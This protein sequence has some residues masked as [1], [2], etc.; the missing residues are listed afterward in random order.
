M[1]VHGC[2]CLIVLK[3][4]HIEIDIPYSSE[5][6]REHI[7]F[8]R[9]EPCIEGDEVCRGL[10]KSIGVTGCVVAPLILRNTPLL[11]LL[12]FGL[13]D[14]SV[15]V[16]ET[17]NV[18]KSR[19]ELVPF[20]DSKLFDLI[21]SRKNNGGFLFEGCRVNAFELRIEREESI[22][23]RI[24]VL[25]ERNRKKYLFDEAFSR[26]AE[27]RFYGDCVT[28]ELKDT[29]TGSVPEGKTNIYGVTI[30][31]KKDNGIKT[32]IQIRRVL[33]NGSDIPAVIDEM[34]ITARLLRDKY[35]ERNYG[36]FS[37]HLKNLVLLS[38]ETNVE[39]PDAVMGMLRY[40]VNGSISAD[41]F[42]SGDNAL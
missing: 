41:V 33:E 36:T 18:Y 32:E 26:E 7:L 28:Y 23:L 34:I 4:S 1:F 40:Y 5:T 25:S 8:L 2:D 38:D 24:D 39:S 6:V 14:T 15:F 21:Q 16:S 31:C 11:L 17:R 9:E 29:S 13:A 19:L 30:V 27:E 20:E 22:K 35:E 12:A 10:I 42:Q 3:T 37:I